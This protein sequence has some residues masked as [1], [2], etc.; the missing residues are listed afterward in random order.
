MKKFLTRTALTGVLAATAMAASA[1]SVNADQVF[2]DDVIIQQSLCV[3]FD[4]VNGESFGFDTLRLKEN[5]LRIHFDDT[6]NSASFPNN[7]WRIL[8]NDTS[9]G[10]GNY[11]AIEDSTAGRQ[12]FRVDAG[13]PSNSLRIDSAGDVGIGADNPVVELHVRDGDSPTLR[14]EQDGSAGFTAQTFDLVANEAN[15]FIR[16]VTNGSQL[17]FRIKPGADTDAL[18]IAAN[19]NVG[20]GTDNPGAALH[21]RGTDGATSLKVEEVGSA[22]YREMLNLTNNG[23]SW[24]TMTNSATTRNWYLVHEDTAPQR[25]IIDTDD[26]AGPEFLLTGDGD[27]TIRGEL[28]TAGSCSIGCDR[29]FADDYELASISD[30]EAAMWNNGYLPG[31]GPTA[32]DGPFNVSQ[33][34]GGMLNELEHA[35]IYIAQLNARV[36][37]LEAAILASAADSQ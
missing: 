28:T 33:K 15:F 27:L 9:N 6:S 37:E 5:N 29:V 31:V 17:P 8:V 13:A 18:F 36:N 25:F 30:H 34:M 19:N 23:G 4:C 35:H 7:D 20:V 26:T 16:D 1:T 22:G 32:E 3:G 24:I 14:L 10:G 12:V 2:V 21:V 11:F